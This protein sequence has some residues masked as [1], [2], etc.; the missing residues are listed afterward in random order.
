[1]KA[2]NTARSRVVPRSGR[3]ALIVD[4]SAAMRDVLCEVLESAGWQVTAAA[5]GQRALRLMIANPPDVVLVDLLMPGMSGFALRSRMLSDATLAAIPVIVLS[6]YWRRPRE[7]L[8]A[9]AVLGK[10]LDIDELMAALEAICGPG[11]A[12]RSGETRGA[13]TTAAAG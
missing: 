12:A 9:A 3:S 11:S 6:A 8:D 2:S 5:T 7:T 10:P 1:M 13:P 4:D